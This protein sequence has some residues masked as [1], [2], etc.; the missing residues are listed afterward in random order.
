VEQVELDQL[1]MVRRLPRARVV[2]RIQFLAEL[3][4]GCRVIHIGFADARC[5]DLQLGAGTWLHAHLERTATSLVGLDVD[6]AGVRAAREAGYVAH[7]VDCREP[8]Q[9]TALGLE[10]AELV[11]AGEV[12]E[13]LDAPGPFLDAVRPL[14]HPEGLLVLTT[15]N[16]SG[17][18]NALGA[19]AG[20]EVNHPD[21]VALFSCHTLTALV[22]RH[23]WFVVEIRTY[24]PRI[25]TTDAPSWKSRL[26][27]VGGAGLQLIERA[28]G[29]VGRPFV[30][31]GLIMV[32]RPVSA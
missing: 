5:R 1:A 10:P 21:H 6:E 23:D 31:D 32:A 11:I 24:V 15:P 20:Y 27:R 4:A 29:R 16:A 19:L 22:E 25:K 14:V 9:V 30:A 8:A 13:H 17:L 18:G 12:I 26:L 3:A 28:A 2:D 7:R